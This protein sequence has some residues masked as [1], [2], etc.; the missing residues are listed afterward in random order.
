MADWQYKLDLSE[1]R[2]QYDEDGDMKAMCNAHAEKIKELVARLRKDHRSIVSE[3][4]ADEL[5]NDVLP[6]FEEIAENGG[7]VED[8]DGSLEVLYDWADTSLD[9]DFFGKKLCWV[10]TRGH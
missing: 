9:D 1:S 10:E 8:Y 6:R 7:D 3:D 4:L 2:K 5:E